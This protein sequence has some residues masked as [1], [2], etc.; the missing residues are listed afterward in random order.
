[1]EETMNTGTE[2]ATLEESNYDYP[3]NT[4]DCGEKP[5]KGFMALMAGAVVAAGAVGTI[6]WRKHKAAKEA[7]IEEEVQRRVEEILEEKAN[8]Q[9]QE[10]EEEPETSEKTE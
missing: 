10:E 1:M 6:A 3:A 5:S 8:S 9:E 7:R 4:C 2:I